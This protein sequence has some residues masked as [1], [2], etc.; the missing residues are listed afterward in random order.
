[1][2]DSGRFRK[3]KRWARLTQES[4]KFHSREDSLEQSVVE[5]VPYADCTKIEASKKKTFQII[6]QRQKYS[7]AAESD[8]ERDDWVRSIRDAQQTWIKE[9]SARIVMG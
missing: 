9:Q 1:V 4:L 5:S 7:L 2:L 3:E 6:T 8:D